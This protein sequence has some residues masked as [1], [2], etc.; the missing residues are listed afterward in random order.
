MPPVQLR[1]RFP[2]RLASAPAHAATRLPATWDRPL[3]ALTARAVTRIELPASRARAGTSP[4]VRLTR[5]ITIGRLP[6][7]P[8][9]RPA[10]RRGAPAPRP[11]AVAR[12]P[13]APRSAL[14]SA[15]GSRG[16]WRRPGARA[17]R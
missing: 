4:I 10:D 16:D 6:T 2:R 7:L 15:T 8:A 17:G 12:S 13:A 9:A 5:L 11:T 3:D 14:R 1:P